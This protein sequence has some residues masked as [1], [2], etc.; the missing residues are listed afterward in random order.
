MKG[1]AGEA[2][3]RRAAAQAAAAAKT[4]REAAI[5]DMDEAKLRIE[6]RSL[7]DQIVGD[8]KKATTESEFSAA[9]LAGLTVEI[10]NLRVEV[11]EQAEQLTKAGDMGAALLQGNEELQEEVEELRATNGDNVDL[12]ARLEDAEHEH[13]TE[14]AE[15]VKREEAAQTQLVNAT[16]KLTKKTDD[17]TRLEDEIEQAQAAAEAAAAARVPAPSQDLTNKINQKEA[18]IVDLKTEIEDLKG[19]NADWKEAYEEKVT[20][21][22]KQKAAI[23]KLTLQI[24]ELTKAKADATNSVNAKIDEMKVM[25]TKMTSNITNLQGENERLRSGVSGPKIGDSQGTMAALRQQVGI[26]KKQEET[27]QHQLEESRRKVRRLSI[28]KH[29]VEM[30]TQDLDTRIRELEVELDRAGGENVELQ[31]TLDTMRLD[32][33]EMIDLGRM[34]ED[35]LNAVVTT[36]DDL[37]KQLH[38]MTAEKDDLKAQL[39]KVDIFSPVPASDGLE[40][41]IVGLDEK[42]VNLEGQI[43]SLE[44]QNMNHREQCDAELDK[45]DGEFQTAMQQ[46]IDKMDARAKEL[47]E[48][49]V[50]QREKELIELRDECQ[51]KLLRVN[52]L[53]STQIDAE[54]GGYDVE[55][56]R[57]RA[58]ITSRETHKD[59]QKKVIQGIIRDLKGEIDN[60]RNLLAAQEKMLSG[61]GQGL[62]DVTK[63]ENDLRTAQDRLAELESIIA[64]L[65]RRQEQ[66]SSTSSVASSASSASSGSSVDYMEANLHPRP[67]RELERIIQDLQAQ[68]NKPCA[69]VQAYEELYAYCVAQGLPNLPPYKKWHHSGEI[70]GPHGG[71]VVS[72]PDDSFWHDNPHVYPTA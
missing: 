35:N 60:L 23:A 24:T 1:G 7:D 2:G 17:V 54:R 34:T 68:L 43:V 64:D 10:G 32:W 45:M 46:A 65:E 6:I 56:R 39:D 38:D 44:G 70:F 4:A 69:L 36:R 29:E 12:A 63:L 18:E 30:K 55:I 67:E 62:Q 72:V 13:T 14:M 49:H 28:E 51:R 40:E 31:K 71:P 58:E 19:S 50:I 27:V 3:E 37:E 59:T 53:C 33:D 22:K 20:E 25:N 41:Q 21:A 8:A 48:G 16:G 42:I 9:E 52:E 47:A 66:M 5:A 11:E 57:L 15:S 26:L 61:D